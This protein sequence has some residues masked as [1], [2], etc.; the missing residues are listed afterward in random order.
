[1]CNQPDCSCNDH[2]SDC[3]C[4]D[5]GCGDCGCNDCGCNDCGCSHTFIET[6]KVPFIDSVPLIPDTTVRTES[7]GYVTNYESKGKLRVKHHNKDDTPP[8]YFKSTV[9]SELLKMNAEELMFINKYGTYVMQY[10]YKPNNGKKGDIIVEGCVYGST[11]LYSTM[12]GAFEVIKGAHN[13]RYVV[14]FNK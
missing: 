11:G 5:C 6:Y 8:K 10:S 14:T 7:S 4:S 2:K 13:L 9:E 3:G 12:N 1:M